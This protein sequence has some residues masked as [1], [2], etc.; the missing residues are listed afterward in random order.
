LFNAVP[1]S[2]Q[3]VTNFTGTGTD[4]ITFY[5]SALKLTYGS[6]AAIN[7]VGAYSGTQQLGIYQ[8]PD[9]TR[10]STPLY[11]LVLD[12]PIGSIHTLFL[13]GT[14]TAP[15]TMFTTDVLPYHPFSDSSLGIRFVNL[16]A[17]SSPIS[18]NIKNNA[19]GSEVSSLSYKGITGFKNYPAPYNVT[20]YN[21]EFRDAA[22]GTL[23]GNLDV[24]GINTLTA[25]VRRF[26]NFTI[27][28]M[29]SPTDPTTRKVSLIETYTTN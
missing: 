24:T 11:N 28:Y 13:T 17:G 25:N 4:S 1:G 19:Y 20:D 22:S 18:V 7:Q 23:L 12:L 10:K 26:R 2:P 8:Y 16:S 15:D 5:K 6:W 9:T 14:L 29:G 21:F 3:L 27:A